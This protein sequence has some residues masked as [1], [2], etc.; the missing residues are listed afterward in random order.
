V[1][2]DF[3]PFQS[4]PESEAAHKTVSRSARLRNLFRMKHKNISKAMREKVLLSLLETG[5]IQET[6][7][8]CKVSENDILRLWDNEDF[9]NKF[10]EASEFLENLRFLILIMEM[11]T[12]TKQE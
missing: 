2:I 1:S 6:S 9:R 5:S 4:S 3:L 7:I 8:R 11:G 12:G 10:R